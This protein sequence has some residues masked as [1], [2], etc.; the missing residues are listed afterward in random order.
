MKEDSIK[1][2]ETILLLL[3]GEK[4]SKILLDYGYGTYLRKAKEIIKQNFITK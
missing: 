3:S 4:E 2:L 1:L